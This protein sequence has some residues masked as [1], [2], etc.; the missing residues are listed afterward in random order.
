M[1]T[2]LLTVGQFVVGL[3]GLT[4][5]AEFF[6]RGAA[7]LAA[8]LRV[9]PVVIGLTVVAFGTSAPELAVTVQAVY[10]PGSDAADLAIGNVV[11]SNIANVLLI[12][13]LA[14]L[15]TP[16]IV[17]DRLVRLDV[18]LM[19]G[20]CVLAYLLCLKG[21]LQWWDG[22]IL[23]GS[24][25]VYLVWLLRA[26]RFRKEDSLDEFAQEYTD[27]QKTHSALDYAIFGIQIVGGLVLLLFG[28]NWIVASAVTVAEWLEVNKLVI[29]LTVVAVGTSLPEIA[30]SVAASLKG[31]RDIAVGNVVG[32]NIFNVLMVLGA[33]AL[34]APGGLPVSEAALLFDLPVM[35]AVVV[36][37]LPIFFTGFKIRRW[38]GAM[39]LVAYFAYTAYLVLNATSHSARDTYVWV[40]TAFVVPITLITI[41]SLA[42][43]E[44]RDRIRKS[45]PA[46]K[47]ADSQP[48]SS[49]EST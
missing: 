9:A 29:G 7:G 33:A 34:L 37:C 42:V 30:T 26:A 27:P 46:T 17:H 6:V 15:V 14:A 22:V 12:L 47:T 49:Q 41:I 13:G 20:A 28:S 31:E 32:S 48:N 23:L 44:L 11:G 19:I 39:F 38:E 18:P 45:R 43:W 3:V 16:L 10:H 25:A 8:A 35:L 24:L 4:A 5:G 36:T 40:M 1:I 2:I 21:S